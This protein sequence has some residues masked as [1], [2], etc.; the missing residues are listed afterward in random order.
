[1]PESYVNAYVRER[2]FSAEMFHESGADM[3]VLDTIV[4]G[5]RR[6]RHYAIATA[7][8]GFWFLFSAVLLSLDGL[9]ILPRP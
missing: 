2:S 7:G 3:P 6:D 4:R 5:C 9:G 8:I 1:M